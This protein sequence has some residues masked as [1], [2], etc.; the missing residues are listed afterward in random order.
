MSRRWAEGAK[1]KRLRRLW[2]VVP[3]GRQGR[4]E[5]RATRPCTRVIQRE[6]VGVAAVKWAV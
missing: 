5:A 6:P 2:G 4:G 1:F 3:V